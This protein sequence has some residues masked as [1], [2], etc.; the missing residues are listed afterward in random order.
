MYAD[1]HATMYGKTSTPDFRGLE[2]YEDHGVE[3]L[4]FWDRNGKLATAVNVACPA[5][6]VE[7]NLA[8]SADYWGQSAGSSTPDT[9]RASWC[10]VDRA[11]GDQSPH[12]MYRKEAEERMRRLR[13][14][15]QPRRN[16]PPHRP[17]L[18]RRLTK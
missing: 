7:S 10:S 17:R 9:A 12:L 14:L 16:R 4:Y 1:G 5:Q 8:V 3:I 6:E 18:G 2:G 11:G 13:G 15:S